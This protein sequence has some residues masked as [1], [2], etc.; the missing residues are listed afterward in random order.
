MFFLV[1]HKT[2]IC[3]N[4]KHKIHQYTY[5]HIDRTQKYG[6]QYIYIYIYRERDRYIYMCQTVLAPGVLI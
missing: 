5:L 4:I 2:Q 3:M 1:S 6:K